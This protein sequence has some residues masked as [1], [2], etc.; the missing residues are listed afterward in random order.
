VEA[1]ISSTAGVYRQLYRFRLPKWSKSEWRL[2]VF[3]ASRAFGE[4]LPDAN[5]GG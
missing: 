5:D 1:G 2:R 3:S 4:Q